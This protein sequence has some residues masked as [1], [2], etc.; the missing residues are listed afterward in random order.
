MVCHS[1]CLTHLTES[2]LELKK[3]MLDLLNLQYNRN[4]VHD[5]ILLA[6]EFGTRCGLIVN[7]PW[8]VP[9]V[10]DAWKMLE[11]DL[12]EPVVAAGDPPGVAHQ[13]WSDGGVRFGVKAF[14]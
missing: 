3:N 2:V 6:G 8:G 5:P 14:W 11:Y 7:G 13:R 12:H 10:D 9:L 1:N 4:E